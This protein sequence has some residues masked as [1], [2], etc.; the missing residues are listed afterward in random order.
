MADRFPR[1]DVL[2]KAESESWDAITRHTIAQR[3]A[4]QERGDLLT[5]RQR[6][7][8]RAII[9]RITPQPAG[10]RPV[11]AAAILLEKI[12][13]V[14]GDGYRHHRLPPLKVAWARG[15]DA[16]E[17]E[18]RASH[19]RAFDTL[20]GEEQDGLLRMVEAGNASDPS[21]RDMPP[22]IFFIWR[23]VPDVVAAYWS[24]PSAWSAMGFG[25]PASPRGYVRLDAD[26]R[27]PWEGAEDAG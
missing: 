11:N 4:L 21:W 14:E 15:L 22:D 23:L 27:D 8:L 20:T 3:I 19:G 25:G 24:H 9:D 12:G 1:Y 7:T 6:L 10:R 13:G 17:A 16:I 2:A 5:D 26:R 18:A